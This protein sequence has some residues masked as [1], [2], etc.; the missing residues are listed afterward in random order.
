MRDKD[1]VNVTESINQSL[2]YKLIEKIRENIARSLHIYFRK[3]N[4]YIR[5][6]YKYIY[7]YNNNTCENFIPLH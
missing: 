2:S 4:M 5:N 1:I 6:I 7:I 3:I